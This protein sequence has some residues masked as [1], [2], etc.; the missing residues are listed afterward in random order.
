MKN[1]FIDTNIVLD[2]LEKREEF[3]KE[4]Q[5]LFSNADQLTKINIFVSALTIANTYYIL[6]KYYTN[7]IVKG[8]VAKFK[9]LVEVLPVN[10]KIIELALLSDFKDFEDA[11]QYYTAIENNMD[12]IITRNKKDFN[13]SELPV[14]TA[15]EFLIIKKTLS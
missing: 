10:D 12:V 4:A 8:I 3:Y 13:L 11:L 5:I 1:I 7:E 2:L 15:K 6:R 14:F 9:I